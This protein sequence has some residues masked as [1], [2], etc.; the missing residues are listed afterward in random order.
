MEL[1]LQIIQLY[2]IWTK[3]YTYQLVQ[4]NT[5][6]KHAEQSTILGRDTQ[7]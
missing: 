7:I 4:Q 2:E 1:S 3:L 6:N 5:Q